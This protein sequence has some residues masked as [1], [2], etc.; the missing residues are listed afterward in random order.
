MTCGTGFQV[1][2]LS[3]RGYTIIG[4]DINR[5]ML[6]IAKKKCRNVK[7]YQGDMRTAQY[8]K[9]DAVITIFNAIGHLNKYDFERTIINISKNLKGDGIY[10]FDIFNLEFMKNNFIN[11]EFMDAAK[12]LENIKVVRFNKNN[13]DVKN[14]IMCINQKTLLQKGLG[15]MKPI[16][17]KWD[18]QIYSSKQLKEMLERNGFEVINFLSLDGKKFNPDKSMSILTVT[19][20]VR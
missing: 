4:S 14:G 20:K 2:Y 1:E 10:I 13:L 18:M 3:K 8:G 16:I 6:N 9:F 5:D 7:F 11:H 19:R 12:E 17:E 15:K